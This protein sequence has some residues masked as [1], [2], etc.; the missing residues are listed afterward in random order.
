MAD[1]PKTTD[2]CVVCGVPYGAEYLACEEPD[3]R[4]KPEQD[5][6]DARADAAVESILAEEPTDGR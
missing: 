4:L 2:Y 3:C 1:D 6:A 5:A